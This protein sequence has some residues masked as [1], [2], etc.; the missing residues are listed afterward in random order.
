MST[1]NVKLYAYNYNQLKTYMVALLFTAGN[2][3]LPQLCHLM[4]AR[5]ANLA[6]YLFFHSRGSL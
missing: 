6:T 2:I 3:I 4:P 1:Q 5:R